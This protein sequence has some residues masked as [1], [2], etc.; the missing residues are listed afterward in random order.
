MFKSRAGCMGTLTKVQGN[1]EELMKN[2]GTLEDLKSKRKSY[3]EVWCK[4]VST[5]EEYIE[6]LEFV[7]YE[8]E[9]EKARL[10]YD[11]QMS[12]KLAFDNVIE[13]W[14]E[15][16]KLES[17]EVSKRSFPLTRKSRR[18]HGSISSYSGSI[19]LSIVKRKVIKGARID[20]FRYI[21][22]QPHTIDLST[23]LWEI[24]TEFVGFIPQSLVLRS[25]V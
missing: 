22:I 9:L 18:S 25:I 6:C 10:S 23:R 20:Q 21:K 11:E 5:H 3:D 13:S 7:C 14:F 2:C 15:K 12:R 16:S 4:F 24:N 17:K 1:I 19:S 8:E